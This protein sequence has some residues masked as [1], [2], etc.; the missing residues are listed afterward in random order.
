MI[1]GKK[2]AEFAK[3]HSVSEARA[4]ELL[5]SNDFIC[6]LVEEIHEGGKVYIVTKYVKGGDLLHYM[7]RVLEVSMLPQDDARNLFRQVAEGVK[8]IHDCGLVHRDLKYLNILISPG[9][10]DSERQPK[11]KITDFG[12]AMKLEPG[13]TFN[14]MAGTVGFVAPEVL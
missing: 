10:E 7:Q 2:Y 3:R 11:V 8:A 6:N 14:K 1:D 13:K 4:M 9:R 5:K 12:L